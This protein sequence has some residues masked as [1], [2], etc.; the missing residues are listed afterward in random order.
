MSSPQ[1]LSE[2]LQ[3]EQ[4]E[5]QQDHHAQLQESLG[6]VQPIPQPIA[7]D[8]TES[9]I[10]L[11]HWNSPRINAYRYYVTNLSFLIM[12]MNDGCLGALLPYIETY[13]SINY[14]IVSTLF[15]VPVVGYVVAALVNNWIH[16]TVGQRGVAFIGPVCRLIAYIPM[17]FHPP[18]PALPCV[19]MFTGFGNGIEDSA[20]NAWVGNMHHAN[21]LLGFLHGS[22]G[23]GATISPLIAS[24]MVTEGHLEWYTFFYIMIGIAVVEFVIGITVFWGATGA[25]YKRRVRFEQGKNHTTTRMAMRQPITWIVAIFFLGYI[26]AEVSLGGWIVTFMLRVR[27]AKPFLAGLTVTLFWLGLTLGRVVLGFVTER[28]GEKLAITG[29]LILSIGLEL[30]YWL[31]PNFVASVIFVMLLGFF[32]GPLFPAAI[33]AATKLLP[34]DYHISA[35]GFAAAIGGGGAAI[36]PTNSLSPDHDVTDADLEAIKNS[37]IAAVYF[38]KISSSSRPRGPSVTMPPTSAPPSSARIVALTPFK[39]DLH[40]RAWVSIPHPTL[41]LLATAHSKAVTVYSLSTASAHSSLTGGHTRSV[42][43][44]AWKPHLPPHRLCLVTGSFDSTAGIW[45]WDGEVQDE[46]GLEVEV[47]ARDVRRRNDD[48]DEDDSKPGDKDWEFTLVL[49]GH[50]SEIKSCAFNPSGTY[51]ATCSRDKSV[52][53][54]EDIGASEADDEWE[55]IAVLNEHEGDVKAVAWCPDVPGRNARRSYS[56][57][58]LAS[59][60]YDN[61]VRIWREDGDAEWVCVAVLEGHEGTVWGLQWEPRP[62][63]GDGFPR[64]LT[65][66]ADGTIRIW[67]LQ[68]D[69]DAE[70]NTAGGSR[71]ALGG[72]PNTM[73]RSLREKWTC[74]AIL[75]KAHTRDIYSVAWS[76]QTGLIASTGSDGIVALYTEGSEGDVPASDGDQPMAEQPAGSSRWRLLT[77]HPSAHGPYEVNHVTWCRRYDAGSERRG[78]EEMLVTTGDDG[79]VQP[80]QVDLD[81]PR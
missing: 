64:L 27:H 39:P 55:T 41:P 31:V 70:E 16:Y 80:W 56:S 45:R 65:F 21:E 73:R 77:A 23:I 35:I 4:G 59:A 54:W 10:E 6:I 37:I 58:V 74:T 19:M 47:T 50:D 75:P 78:E 7:D 71:S 68:E 66:S 15:A 20:Y 49:E 57:D 2:P 11:E 13:Y 81:V 76:A 25:E 48:S 69:E 30:L 60:S 38:F 72:I 18:F 28:T 26:A 22:Y 40:E 12:G 29:Y 17:A 62:R 36:D 14:T 43:S 24:A 51:L 46:G 34:A 63:P 1:T 9:N 61:T 79:I 32:L 44:V 5:N 33:V 8:S 3:V 67:T 52:W 42:R 53:I